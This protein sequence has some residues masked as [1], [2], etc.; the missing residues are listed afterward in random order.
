MNNLQ[1]PEWS[2]VLISDTIS[3]IQTGVSVNS[4]NKRRGANEIGILKTSCISRGQFFPDEHKVVIAD[5]IERVKTPLK[6]ESILM[7]RMN[8]PNLVGEVGYVKNQHPGIYLPDRLW[9]FEGKTGTADT[10]FLSHLLSSDGF[11]Q[12]LSDIATGTSGSMKNIPQRSFL[13]IPIDLPPLPEQKK[14]A[15]IISGI[16][17][18]IYSLECQRNKRLLTYQDLLDDHFR[19]SLEISSIPLGRT[20]SRSIEYG[21]NASASPL[22]RSGLRFLRI[23]DIKED[24]TLSEAGAVG[25]SLTQD[26]RN[27]YQVS[28]GDVLLARTGNTVGKSYL[29]KESDGK[30]AF[31]GYLLRIT[32]DKDICLPE[33]FFL[34][35]QS[36]IYKKWVSD[37]CRTGAQ[38]NINAKEY[39]AMPVPSKPINDQQLF[40]EAVMAFRDSISAID[41][42]IRKQSQLKQALANDLLLGRK[43]VSV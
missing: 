42:K 43:R 13:Q 26:E 6:A 15:E 36:S 7:S 9:M 18:S 23:T 11:R 38:P 12:K 29:Y 3:E 2:E 24:G 22:E 40:T 28:K 21:A 8:T 17:K 41:Q 35:T 4:E 14:I 33:Y 20:L 34:Y 19:R 30:L 16:D 32:P 5:E 1:I 27:K 39:G 25:V 37:T 10:L 31:A